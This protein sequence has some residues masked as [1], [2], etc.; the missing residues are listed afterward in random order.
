MPFGPPQLG[1]G[2]P[3]RAIRCAEMAAQLADWDDDGIRDT[4]VRVLLSF[5][6]NEAAWELVRRALRQNPKVD[7]FDDVTTSQCFQTWLA[8]TR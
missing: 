6:L 1:R 8:R 4:K 7:C 3:Q 5:G 2:E